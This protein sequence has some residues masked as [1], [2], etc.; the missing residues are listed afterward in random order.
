MEKVHPQTD[1]DTPDSETNTGMYRQTHVTYR[2]KDTSLDTE[3]H[4]QRQ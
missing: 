4:T 2:Y 1:M 3:T